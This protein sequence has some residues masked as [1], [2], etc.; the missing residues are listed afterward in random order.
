MALVNMREMLEKARRGSYCV[1]AFNVDNLELIRAVVE[2]AEMEESPV[3]IEILEP[4]VKEIG[5]EL[6]AMVARSFAESVNV[7]VAVHLDHGLSVETCKRC[8]DAGFTS[9]MIDSSFKP[10][11]EN[12]SDTKAVVEYAKKYDATVEGEIGQVAGLEAGPENLDKD[13]VFSDPEE[14]AEYCKKSGVDCVGVSI[15][16]VHYMRKD[17]LNL[18]F[19]LLREIRETVDIPLV[20]H[21]GA[22]VTDDDMKTAVELGICKY[23]IMYKG[24]KAFLAGMKESLDNLNEEVVPGKL[25]VFP[26][27]TIR[28]GLDFAVE[29]YRSKI[30]LLGGSGKANG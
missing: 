4:C 2:A 3:I 30:R 28:N 7:P 8:L 26:Y 22:A 5:P 23:N 15:G 19:G 24:Y 27:R 11:E 13:V 9:V 16:T 10:F 21:G 12:V 25:M 29:E 18:N 14:V 1:C 17:P 6:F 20:L